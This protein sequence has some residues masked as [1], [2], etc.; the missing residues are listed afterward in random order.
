MTLETI[1]NIR[2]LTPNEGKLLCNMTD[3]IIS[4]KV[5]LAKNADETLW[6]EI[7][8]SKKNTYESMWY[9]EID[10]SDSEYAEVGKILLGVAE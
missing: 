6:T 4:D 7:E 1:N 9:N 8:E 10:D 3:K 2:I 5:Y